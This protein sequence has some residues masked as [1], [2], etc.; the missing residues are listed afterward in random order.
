MNDLSL[1]VSNVLGEN[2]T[3]SG[4]RDLSPYHR[5]RRNRDGN[6]SI[7]Q[8]INRKKH[9]HI[10]DGQYILISHGLQLN[11]S[12]FSW[13]RSSRK[14]KHATETSRQLSMEKE[15][16]LKRVSVLV[17]CAAC[18]VDSCIARSSLP[19]LST[20]SPTPKKITSHQ[21]LHSSNLGD[22][23]QYRKLLLIRPPVIGPYTCKQKKYIGL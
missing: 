23:L 14:K 7:P 15:N 18:T 2:S 6:F 16:K 12:C 19:F 11:I 8:P 20:F 10:S 13:K 3:R 4:C 9:F 17:S 22:F 21:Y 5:D 1:G